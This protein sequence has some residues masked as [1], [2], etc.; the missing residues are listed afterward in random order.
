MRLTPNHWYDLYSSASS[1]I[2]TQPGGLPTS[3][4][5]IL[6]A[7]AVSANIISVIWEEGPFSNGPILSYILQINEQ[8]VG[9]ATVKVH[10]NLYNIILMGIGA[11]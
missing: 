11:S 9:F 4:P 8:P 3:S 2:A 10:T 6:T 7:T 5:K 1:I